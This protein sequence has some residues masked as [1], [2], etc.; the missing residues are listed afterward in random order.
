MFSAMIR[1]TERGG[2]RRGLQLAWLLALLCFFSAC[3]ARPEGET[4]SIVPILSPPALTVVART[5]TAAATPA[6]TALPATLAPKVTPPTPAITAPT[7]IPSAAPTALPRDTA[8]VVPPGY[9]AE[10]Y[11]QGL[12]QPTALAF[13]PDRRLYVAQ[14]SGEIVVLDRPGAAPQR[15]ISGLERPLGLVWRKADLYVMSQGTL[16]VFQGSGA[17]AGQRRDL[18]TGIPT[19]GMQNNNLVLGADGWIYVGIGSLCDHCQP[20]NEISGQIRRLR[21]DG[22]GW[23]TYATGLRNNFGLTVAPD[24]ALWGTDNGREELPPGL[25]P[26][27]LNRIVA[28]G[29]YGWPRCYGERVPDPAGGGNTRN[30]AATIPPVATFPAH[31]SPVGLVFYTGGTFAPDD[32]GALFVGLAGAWDRSA[33]VGRRI[34]RVRLRGDAPAETTDWSSGWGRPI[35]LIT[36][37]DGALLVA[38]LDRG[39]ITRIVWMG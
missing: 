34:V 1:Q 5:S 28:G 6:L 27:E 36:A 7:P 20:E 32:N 35:G 9:R 2:L 37:P 4:P 26:E 21:P 38:D 17:T 39:T 23:Q 8:V 16:S 13:G 24:G 3:T 31:S 33:L 29:D 10:R 19:A 25:P 30:C 12:A 22:S 14:L 15:Y 11:A 18:L